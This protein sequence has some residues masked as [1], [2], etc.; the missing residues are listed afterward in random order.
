M[1]LSAALPDDLLHALLARVRETLPGP[2]GS[3]PVGLA[4]AAITWSRAAAANGEVAAALRSALDA[5][6]SGP[7]A[8]AMAPRLDLPPP[9]SSTR[10]LLDRVRSWLEAQRTDSRE[11]SS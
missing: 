1:A 10:P 6:W 5:G 11:V 3:S 7:E 8:C 9:P 2:L 4:R